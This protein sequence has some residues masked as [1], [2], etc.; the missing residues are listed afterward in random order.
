MLGAPTHS[1]DR[2]NPPTVARQRRERRGVEAHEVG[3]AHVLVGFVGVAHRGDPGAVVGVLQVDVG[4][5]S[6]PNLRFAV[7][8]PS[9]TFS[10]DP[11]PEYESSSRR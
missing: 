11:S 5:T 7:D 10:V 3:D 8:L 1:L 9:A 4:V 2:N 6:S